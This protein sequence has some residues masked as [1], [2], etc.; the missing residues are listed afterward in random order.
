MRTLW[1]DEGLRSL[2]AEK[3]RRRLE[4]HFARRVPP[5]ARRAYSRARTCVSE[6]AMLRPR[7]WGT[8]R[9]ASDSF[10]RGGEECR[11]T[12]VRLTLCAGRTDLP[13]DGT[14]DEI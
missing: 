3:G 8:D 5:A 4:P 1:T 6:R 14:T 7:V 13:W 2:L 11:Q 10:L 12:S 9:R